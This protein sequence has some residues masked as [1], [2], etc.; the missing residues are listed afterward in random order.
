MA[1][2]FKQILIYRAFDTVLLVSETAEA[3]EIA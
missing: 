1:S 2:A 3:V